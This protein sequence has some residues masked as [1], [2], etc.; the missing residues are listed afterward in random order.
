MLCN[1]DGSVNEEMA[2]KMGQA[3]AKAVVTYYNLKPRTAEADSNT[4]VTLQKG[5]GLTLSVPSG[6]TNGISWYSI[7][8]MWHPLMKTVL[9]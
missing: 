1:T 6:D 4:S 8:K 3:D 2:A 7:D 9:R 5:Y